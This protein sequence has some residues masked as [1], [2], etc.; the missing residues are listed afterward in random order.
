M[1]LLLL[2]PQPWEPQGIAVRQ[3]SQEESKILLYGHGPS[4]EEVVRYLEP[5]NPVNAAGRELRRW[6]SYDRPT[7]QGRTRRDPKKAPSFGA[8]FKPGSGR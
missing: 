3:R 5:S 8:D 2:K 1:E 4:V 7:M 6:K